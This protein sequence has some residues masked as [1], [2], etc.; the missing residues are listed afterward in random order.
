MSIVEDSSVTF[1]LFSL[2]F[3]SFS[4]FSLYFFILKIFIVVMYDDS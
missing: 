3:T 2:F 4:N 1:S